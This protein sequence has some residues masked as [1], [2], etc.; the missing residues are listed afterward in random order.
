MVQ[1]SRNVNIDRLFD[2]KTAAGRIEPITISAGFQIGNLLRLTERPG[3]AR[4]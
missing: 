4:S 3:S 2:R 1:L